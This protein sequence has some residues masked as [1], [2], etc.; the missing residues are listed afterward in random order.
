MT[1]AKRKW[2]DHQYWVQSHSDTYMDP[3]QRIVDDMYVASL[4][5]E[6]PGYLRRVLIR[7]YWNGETQ[8]QIAAMSKRR[9]NSHG[10]RITRSMVSR[11]HTEALNRL[12]A[13]I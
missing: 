9:E 6:L 1:E 5:E 2:L 12:R 7:I 3:E 13:M 11:R 10:K 8:E 4:L